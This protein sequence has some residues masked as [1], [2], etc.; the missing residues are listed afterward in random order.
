M[1]SMTAKNSISMLKRK[2]LFFFIVG[3]KKL[4]LE[5][6]TGVF[7]GAICIIAS[8][9]NAQPC[10]VA[11]TVGGYPIPKKCFEIVSVL[12]DACDGSNEGQ[13][14]M[15]RLIIGN[16]TLAPGLM[17]V[18]DYQAGRVN[19]GFGAQNSFRGFSEGSSSLNMKIDKINQ[20]IANAGSCGHLVFVANSGRIPQLS[21]LL[22]ITSESFNPDAQDFSDLQDT[23]YVLVQKSGNTAGHF[24]N[25]GTA[26]SREFILNYNTDCG[27]TV[28]YDR[29]K[30][31]K[32]SGAIGGEDGAV[33]DFD[34]TGSATYTNYGCRVPAPRI[35]VVVS[36]LANPPCGVTEVTVNGTV[37]GS[38]CY[39]WRLE[40]GSFGY[41]DK[42]TQLSSK[43]TIKPSFS[44]K[45]KIILQAWGS[46]AIPVA[47]T[48]EIVIVPGPMADF[49][50]DSTAKPVYCFK[51]TDKFGD[52]WIWGGGNFNWDTGFSSV[53]WCDSFSP[54]KHRICLEV[55]GK[56][57]CKDT[58]CKEFMV[59][60]VAI[61]P[62]D[63]FF[64][65]AN[66]FTP[67]EPLDGKNDVWRFPHKGVLEFSVKVY[68][69]WGQLVFESN[70]PKIGWN[71]R[72]MNTGPFLPGGTYVYSIKYRLE[73]S[74]TAVKNNGVV[75]LIR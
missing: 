3:C 56:T 17:S 30:L 4:I 66:V 44:G 72:V 29:S 15:I 10:S 18:P 31:V 50:I 12:V 23:L 19:W 42:P 39:Q 48:L 20:K 25:F 60:E 74:Y 6:G 8:L 9:G 55:I 34:Y 33:V 38:K 46:C 49:E 68:N 36:P 22:I 32:I 71:G 58:L 16:K 61:E 53:S 64:N 40:N 54:G 14:E 1:D 11:G 75:T 47:D 5:R 27:D 24:V 63:P 69:R 21:Q 52:K 67:G 35:R 70:D 57:G 37:T 59:P 41:F 43:L 45:L 51:R 2:L 65:L 26:S 62:E 28:Q 13:N 73:N 7:F